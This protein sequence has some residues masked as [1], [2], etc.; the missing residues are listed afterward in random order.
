MRRAAL[1]FGSVLLAAAGCSNEIPSNFE[2]PGILRQALAGVSEVS[3]RASLLPGGAELELKRGEDGVTFTGFIPA[4]PGEYTL[5]IAFSGK[6]T[7]NPNPLFLGRW[8]SDIFTVTRGNAAQATFSRPLDA[9]GRPA[10][11]GDVDQDGLANLDE[12][13]SHTDPALEDSDSDGL[14]DGEDCDPA[15]GMR[16]V[17]IAPGGSVRDC[18][19]DG[20]TRRGPPFGGDDCDD[21][22]GDIHPGA[23]DHCEDAIDSDCDPSSCPVDDTN[24]PMVSDFRPDSL[25]PIGCQARISAVLHDDS[26]VTSALLAFP[27]DPYPN[28]T[29]RLLLMHSDPLGGERW[30]SSQIEDASGITPLTEGNHRIQIRAYDDHGNTGYGEH[31]IQLAYGVPHIVSLTPDQLPSSGMVQIQIASTVAHG[32]PHVKIYAAP[33]GGDGFFHGTDAVMVADGT[34][35]QVTLSIDTGALTAGEYL[36]FPVIGDDIGNELSPYLSGILSAS[37]TGYYPCVTGANEDIPT[38]VLMVGNTG[39]TPATMRD[40]LAEAVS[41]ANAVDPA[42]RLTQ[43]V[44][45]GVRPDGKVPLDSTTDYSPRWSF[46]FYN[47]S[48]QTW[49]EVAWLTFAFGQPNPYVTPNAGN[50]SSTDFIADPNALIDSDRA[51]QIYATIPNCPGLTGDDGDLVQYLRDADTSQDVLQVGAMSKYWRATATDPPVT[52]SPCSP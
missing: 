33:R 25:I 51:A 45:I 28:S 37:M 31:T 41:R 29:E 35:G 27:D 48:T 46:G 26:L 49:L 14:K 16:S 2:M 4:E 50:I 6:F 32:T 38:R 5:E 12:I 42:A 11:L 44:G 23:T 30:E 18:D 19:A 13:L 52:I 24:P 9:L 47:A 8:T 36:L 10:D 21:G 15:D 22:A 34:G 7:G 17:K 20:Y 1:I 40:V 39:F 43:I 3:A